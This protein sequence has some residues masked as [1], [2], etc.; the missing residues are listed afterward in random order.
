MHKA[1]INGGIE[2]AWRLRSGSTLREL[3]KRSAVVEK[4]RYL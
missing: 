1:S 2:E 3:E 4:E